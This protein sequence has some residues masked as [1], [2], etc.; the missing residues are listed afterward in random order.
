MVAEPEKKL[1]SAPSSGAK[2][3]QLLPAR[4]A[5]CLPITDTAD[6]SPPSII[7]FTNTS[8]PNSANSGFV[9]RTAVWDDTDVILDPHSREPKL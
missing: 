9:I 6:C 5:M 1:P 3:G 2:R 8:A 7:K 4:Y